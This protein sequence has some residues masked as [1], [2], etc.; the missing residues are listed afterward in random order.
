[1]NMSASQC[2]SGCESGW[3]LYLD[4]SSYSQKRC[5]KFSRSF[6]VE[7]EEQDLSMVSD[8]SSGPRHYCQDYEECLDENGCFCSTPAPPEPA[9]KSSKNKKKIKEHGS[10]QQHSYLDDTASSPVIS[11]SK[12]NCRKEASIDLLDFSQ[13][14]SGTHIKGK[15]AF[16]KKIGFLK[17]GKTS[18]K[19]SGGFQEGNWE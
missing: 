19:D 7:D 1:M 13:G 10:N 14:F 2:G 6:R 4:Q 12:K 15:S 8:A 11:F 5:Q 3:T 18:S 9:K 16:H 17:S